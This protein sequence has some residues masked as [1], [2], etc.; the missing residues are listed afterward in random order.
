[1]NDVRKTVVCMLM[2]LILAVPALA[3]TEER[4]I[5]RVKEIDPSAEAAIKFYVY[6]DQDNRSWSYP[7]KS[8]DGAWVVYFDG[9]NGLEFRGMPGLSARTRRSISVDRKQSLTGISWNTVQE[10]SSRVFQNRMEVSMPMPGRWSRRKWWK[11]IP[12]E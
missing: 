4:A 3:M 10:I 6:P 9:E 8:L 12:M 5:E 1:M 11:W 2:L 7:E